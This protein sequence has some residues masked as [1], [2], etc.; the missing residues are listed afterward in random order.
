MARPWRLRGADERDWRQAEFAVLDFETTSGDPR[1]ATPLSVGWVVIGNGRVRLADARYHLIEHRED[2]PLASLRVHR[3]LPA[4]LREGVPV[5]GVAERL[6]AVLADRVIVAH[7]AWIERTVLERMN[8]ARRPLV[9]TLAVVRRLDERA[10]RGGHPG[11]LAV[12]ARRFGV[13]PLRAHHAFGD[14]LTTALLLLVIAGRME[15]QRGRCIV[16]DLVR[17]GRV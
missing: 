9:D 10:G 2:V 8:I 3:L 4:E 15:R 16:D 5:D 6:R 1:R 14:A 12:M 7:G 13:P 17:L 11:S